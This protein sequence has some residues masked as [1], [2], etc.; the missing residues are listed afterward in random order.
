MRDILCKISF[1]SFNN[2]MEI[3]NKVSA[4]DSF[5][6]IVCDIMQLTSAIYDDFPEETK[7]SSSNSDEEHDCNFWHLK[8]SREEIRPLKKEFEFLEKHSLVKK[9]I[10]EENEESSEDDDVMF[11]S[12]SKIKK[13][14]KVLNE[15]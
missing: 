15:V 7:F 10:F 12:S 8:S 9:V 1:L 14:M 6:K 5:K 4:E 3:E 13:K 11:P 2:K